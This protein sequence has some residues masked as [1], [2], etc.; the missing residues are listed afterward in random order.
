MSQLA[1]GERPLD[2]LVDAVTE[3]TDEDPES[4]RRWL[5]P[6]TDGGTVTPA[7]VEA[8]VTDV[9]Q[10]IAT[11]ETRA[12]LATRA[13]ESAGDA[14]ADAPDLDVVDVR[15]REFDERLADL[16]EEVQALGA[17][18]GAATDDLDSPVRVYR[19]A[20]ELHDITTDA[21]NVVRTAHDLET[22][23]EAFE[24]WLD[25]ADRRHDGLAADVD[26]AAESAESVAETVASLREATD[27]DRARRF[28]AAVQTRVLDVVVDDLRAEAA[29][30]RAWAER[31]GADF[32]TD[33]DAR[34]DEVETEVAAS[35]E[36]LADGPSLDGEFGDRL[37]ELD[38]ALSDVEPPVAWGL[39]DETVAEAR[40]SASADEPATGPAASD[41]TGPSESGRAVD[42]NG[43]R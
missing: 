24:A 8:T 36:A 20:V 35:A 25:S 33:V 23:L 34:I 29:D 40:A 31:D 9:S 28:D 42:R 3:R 17:A 19:A 1:L 6:F 21:Q 13:R 39:V 18:L 5:D 38:A 4:V 14:V 27:P 32:P 10:I 15:D 12:D 26:A 41:D 16:R 2:E 30:L 43:A 11:A 22:E 37:D 7:A